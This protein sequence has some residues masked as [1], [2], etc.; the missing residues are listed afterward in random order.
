MAIDPNLVFVNGIDPETGNY[1][2]PPR[3][4]D[5]LAQ[6]VR[7]DPAVGPY[8]RLV[9]SDL[10]IS[11]RAPFGVALEDIKEAGWGI[12]FPEGTPQDVRDAL[13]PLIK[14]RGNQ[15]T[16]VKELD[17][18]TGEQIRDWYQRHG[19]SPGNFDRELVPYYLL[20]VGSPTS[21][22]YEFQY[23]LGVEYAVG[24]LAFETASDYEHYVRSVLDYEKVSSVPN[25]KQIAYWGTRHPADPATNLSASLLIEPL[26]NGIP[27]AAGKFQRPIHSE[28]GYDRALYLGDDATKANLLDVFHA[29]KPP[30][31]IFTASHGL[32]IPSGRPNQVT[33]QGALLC[34][35]W[36][37]FG[38][39]HP[40]HFLASSDIPDDINVNGVVAFCFA[41]FSAGTPDR[42]QFA[43]TLSQAGNLP[44]L[45]PQPFV[46]ALPQRLLTHPK[47][48][49]LA[50]IGHIDRAWGFSIQAPKTTGAQIV[51]FRDSL[52]F[53]LTGSPVGYALAQQFGARFAAL[54]TML[55]NAVSPTAPTQ[56]TDRDVVT[57]WLERNDAQNYVMLGDPSVCIRKDAI[58]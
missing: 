6:A 14:V 21:I 30:A 42:D 55:L 29:P 17:Y 49:A 40:E 7:V 53:I 25:T 37:G 13:T 45:S 41:C 34:Q 23:L 8:S 12:I 44:P 57:Y 9:G 26:A 5:D 36:P 51:P 33:N 54:S 38:A 56:S 52:G 11:F 43:M 32:A 47:G 16:F 4:I 15:S 46:A 2:F 28:V 39:V 19:I 24:R 27:G 3:S 58:V 22:P 18:K 50:V 1:A 48:S 31:M 35:D 10:G 20:L